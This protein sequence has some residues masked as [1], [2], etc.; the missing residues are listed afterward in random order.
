MKNVHSVRYILMNKL[1]LS[2]Q[3]LPAWSRAVLSHIHSSP[4]AH[5]L[6]ADV[7]G[8][9]LSIGKAAIQG[10]KETLQ[11]NLSKRSAPI[12]GDDLVGWF[13]FCTH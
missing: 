2:R 11:H 1:G 9:L 13:K 3:K 8:N 6:E 5:S 7:S 4:A 10:D 12:S